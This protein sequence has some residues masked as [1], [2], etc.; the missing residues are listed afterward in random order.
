MEETAMGNLATH[1]TSHEPSMSPWLLG[2][3]L[4]PILD[5]PKA[6]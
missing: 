5:F 1:Q 4:P 3:S 2:I 6:R